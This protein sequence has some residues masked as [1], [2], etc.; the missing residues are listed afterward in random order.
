MFSH[1]LND[2]LSSFVLNIP[3]FILDSGIHSHKDGET[4]LNV[5]SDVPKVGGD[6]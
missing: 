6:N 2:E 1:L 4:C 3:P 5:V